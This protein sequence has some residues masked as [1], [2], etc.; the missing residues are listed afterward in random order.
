MVTAPPTP[1]V[2]LLPAGE[3]VPAVVLR[4]Q[5]GHR[6]VLGEARGVATAIGFIY[7]RCP[8]PD[9]C[10]LVSAK[11]AALQASTRPDELRLAEITLDPE[12]DTVATLARYGALFGADPARWS[13]ATGD[14]ASVRTLERRLGVEATLKPDGTIVHS[15]TLVLLDPRGRIADRIEG[16]ELGAGPDRRRGTGTRRPRGQ[17]AGPVGVGADARR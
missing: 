3:A 2:P 7:T 14:P 15:D 16:F 8:L 5:R 17:S 4:D 13:L 6:V 1:F 11:F 10:P 9:E 12:H